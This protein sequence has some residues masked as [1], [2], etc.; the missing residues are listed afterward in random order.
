MTDA[1]TRTP[2]LLA[3]TLAGLAL[4]L[5]PL[6]GC[7]GGG[8]DCVPGTEVCNG[9]DDDCDG[10]VDDVAPAACYFGPA[11]TAGV[12]AC[13]AGISACAGGVDVCTGQVLPVAETCNGVDDDCNALVDDLPTTPCYTG[14]AGTEGVGPCHAGQ[15]TCASGTFVCLNEVLPV[16]EACNGADDNCNALIDDGLTCP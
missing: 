2:R 16:P 14:P 1:A 13:R 5:L 3:A 12:G 15:L 7:G 8:G 9:K 11:G 6:G 4:G 10:I